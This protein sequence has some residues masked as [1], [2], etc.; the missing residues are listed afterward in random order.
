MLR[1]FVP[2]NY[3]GNDATG[4]GSDFVAF[5]LGNGERD[6]TRDSAGNGFA[7]NRAGEKRG[8]LQSR[9]A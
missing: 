7:V 2:G 1:P 5:L 8:A 3:L 9:T 4:I 6:A